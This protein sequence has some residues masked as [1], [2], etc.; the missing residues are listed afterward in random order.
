M[1]YAL[2]LCN[3]LVLA[4]CT[5]SPADYGI[6]GPAT[7]VE[8]PPPDDSS[9]DRPGIRDPGAGYGPSVAPT[10]GTGRFFNYN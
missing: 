5:G 8:A 9:I 1:R 4:G 6:T 7:P 3:L 10:T 2:L